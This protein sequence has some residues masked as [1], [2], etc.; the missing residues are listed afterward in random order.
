MAQIRFNN[1]DT[2]NYQNAQNSNNIG[3]FFLKN[4]QD[5]A[6]VRIMHDSVDSFDLVT[7]HN[8]TVGGKQRKVNCLRDPRE[9][10][11][12]CPLCKAGMPV[13]QRLYIHLLCYTRDETGKVIA[14][15]QIWE[16]AASYAVNLK[17]L[18]DNYGTLSDCLFKIKRNGRPGDTNTTYDIMFANPNVYVPDLYPKDANAFANYSALGYPVLNKTYDELDAFI[19]TGEFPP[20]QTKTQA[21]TSSYTAPVQTAAPV[22]NSYTYT[23]VN[24]TVTEAPLSYSPVQVT[25]VQSSTTTAP[26]Q[27]PGPITRPERKY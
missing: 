11:D 6:L 8:V 26:W 16:R 20:K 22:N 27:T 15:P 12:Q 9:P 25:P 23:P 2:A 21:L 1:I 10:L 24:T 13:Q 19:N 3:F 4:D 5:E 14:Q 18:I 17:N 7:V